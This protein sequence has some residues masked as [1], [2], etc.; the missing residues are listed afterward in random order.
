MTFS[1]VHGAS[2]SRGDQVSVMPQIETRPA[3]SP[4]TVVERPRDRILLWAADPDLDG[5]HAIGDHR[6]HLGVRGADAEVGADG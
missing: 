4:W 6:E 3:L 1:E 5:Q 2:R